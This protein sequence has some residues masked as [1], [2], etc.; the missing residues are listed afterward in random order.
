MLMRNEADI[1]ESWVRYYAKEVDHIIITNN[2]SVDGSGDLMH[3]LIAEGL[4]ITLEEDNRHGFLQ[5]ERM[6]KMMRRAFSEFKADWVLLLDADEILI[7]PAGKTLRETFTALK[8][9]RLLKVPLFTYVPMECDS[10]E[11]NVL[12][13]ITHRLDNEVTQCNKVMVPATIGRK[14]KAVIKM[15]NHNMAMRGRLIKKQDAPLGMYLAHFPVRS[16][17]QLATKALVGWLSLLARPNYNHG[18]CYHWKN[19]FDQFF[20]DKEGAFN[21]LQDVAIN[22]VR[23]SE[24]KNESPNVISDPIEYYKISSEFKK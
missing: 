2:L 8:D 5:N 21:D 9:D 3:K 22:Y 10:D 24:N 18:D 12:K 6:Q 1:I 4:P 16:K 11:P 13:R 7:P 17:E 20:D 14:Q 23:E 15:G 19:L